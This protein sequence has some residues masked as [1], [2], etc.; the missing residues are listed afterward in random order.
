MTYTSTN[1]ANINITTNTSSV[2]QEFKLVRDNTISGNKVISSGRYIIMSSKKTSQVLDIKSG[3]KANKANVQLYKSNN[4][5][6]QKFNIIY[7]GNGYYSITNAK[8]WQ[9]TYNGSCAQLW[10]IK[11][12]GNGTYTFINR[13]SRKVLDLAGGKT[14]NKTNV[15][16][17]TSNNS[18][19]QRF[20]LK[21]A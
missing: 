16:I 9:Y 6:A 20:K 13:C 2:N 21:K 1:N 14:A 12:N 17:Y 7:R 11:S 10:V 5:L 8:V 18:A 4:T 15:Q 3:S 19:A